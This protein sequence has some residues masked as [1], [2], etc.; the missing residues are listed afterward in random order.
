[1][2]TSDIP[3]VCICC[4]REIERRTRKTGEPRM[5]TI[6]LAVYVPLEKSGVTKGTP[7]VRIC[8]KCL[9]TATAAPWSAEGEKLHGA[10]TG[11]LAALYRTTEGAKAA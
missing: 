11:R 3:R 8:S 1:V 2:T 7:G 6:C 9:S 4:G 10:I 5:I